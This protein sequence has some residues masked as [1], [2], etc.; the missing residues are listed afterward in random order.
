M[1]IANADGSIVLTTNVDDSGLK[2]S[3][4]NLKS[5]AAKLAAEYRKA[6]MSKSEAMKKAWSEINRTNKE[7]K[8]TTKSTKEYGKQAQKSGSTAKKAFSGVGSSLKSLSVVA[9]AAFSVHKL[10]EFGKEAINLASD[11][12]EV[13]N[14]VDVAF[15]EM[16]YKI[17]EFSKTAIES[18][19]ISELTAKR[20]ASTYMA[21]AKGMGIA[22]EAGSDMAITLTGLTADMASFYNVSQDVADTAIKSIFTG[23]TESLKQFGIVMT[24]VNLQEFARQKGINKSISAMTQQEKT[25]LRYEYVLQQTALAQGDFVRT[26]DSWANQTRVLQERWKEMQVTFGETFVALGTLVLPVINAIIEG[27]NK[28]AIAFRMVVESL[29]LLRNAETS[30]AKTTN[31]QVKNSQTTA[32]NIGEQVENQK[33]LNRELKKTTASFDTVE[34]LS[35]G[36]AQEASAEPI[37]PEISGGGLGEIIQTEETQ[38]EASAL[39]AIFEQISTTIKKAWN[40]EPVQ[41]FWEAAKSYGGFLWDYWSTLGT[42]LWVN[43]KTTW[44]NIESDFNTMTSNMSSLWTT[45]W[46]DVQVGIDTWGQPIIEGVNGVFNSM[47]TTAF[48]PYIQLMIGAWS[49]FAG[50]LKSKWEEYGQPLID[51]I[52]QFATNVIAFFQSI[53][54]NVLEPIITP[55]L[56]TMSSLWDEHMS[57]MIDKVVDFVMK[58]VNG[59]LEIYNKFINPIVMWLLKY[60]KPTFVAIGKFISGIFNSIVSWISDVLSGVFKSLG[61]LVDFIVGVFTGDWEQAWNGIKA[62]FVGIWDAIWAAIKGVINLII[63]GL[64]FLWEG[65][66]ISLARIINGVGGIIE[67]I[68]DLIGADWGWEIPS[69]PPLIPKLAQ[70][71]VVPP[72]KEFMA[73]LGDNTKEHEIVSPVSTM[74]QAFVEAMLEMGGNFGGGNTEVVLEIDGRE[75]GRAVVEQGNRENRRIGTRLVIA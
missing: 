58:L 50:I 65:L 54:D 9:A 16:S 35:A 27:L 56:Q 14:V 40:S 8:K 55:F 7:T 1:A 17:E 52:G 12:Q 23:E 61:G 36:M 39:E 31:E 63:D 6:G 34:I 38:K 19:G 4:R 70:G 57:V 44:G 30:T 66:Y 53:Y 49:D 5:E 29:G 28:I 42:S 10:V 32:D 60:L 68:G 74:K 73:I 46:Q 11:L 47:W 45:F 62:Y 20:T 51:N 48:D 15:G 37:I 69:N 64:N 24:E 43:L 71:T 18:F 59:A 3:T 72:N 33:E 22:E 26:Q 21:M 25:M 75:F 13:Q 41:A 2:Q 67:G